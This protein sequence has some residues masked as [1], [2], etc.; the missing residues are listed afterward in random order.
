MVEDISMKEKVAIH[1]RGYS[2]HRNKEVTIEQFLKYSDEARGSKTLHS[3]M[4]KP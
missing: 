1:L 2:T 3:L 4:S